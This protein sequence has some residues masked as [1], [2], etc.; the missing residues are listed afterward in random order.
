MRRRRIGHNR[1][2]ETAAG[3]TPRIVTTPEPVENF[4]PVAC[5]HSWSFVGDS[6]H[7]TRQVD[8]DG[9]TGRGELHCVVE[10]VDQ[11]PFEGARIADKLSR[12]G[13]D[14]D[15]SSPGATRDPL[16][17]EVQYGIQPKAKRGALDARIL[18]REDHELTYERGHLFQL[19]GDAG[20]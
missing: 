13:L 7:T 1:H 9:R 2:S 4:V 19:G 10:H 11:R 12:L 15:A 8:G 20:E 5:G 17:G 6:H 16:D 18:M 14:D 3:R